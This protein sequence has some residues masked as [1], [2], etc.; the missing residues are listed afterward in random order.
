MKHRHPSTCWKKPASWKWCSVV[1]HVPGK[2]PQMQTAAPQ[3]KKK[4]IKNNIFFPFVGTGDRTQGLTLLHHGILFTLECGRE[5]TAFATEQWTELHGN[6]GRS[7]ASFKQSYFREELGI[8]KKMTDLLILWDIHFCFVLKEKSECW[9]CR[10]A[11]NPSTW[12]AG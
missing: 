2:R 12:K 9:V 5:E 8:G 7:G 11:D 3:E 4:R 6:K 10:L 1:A